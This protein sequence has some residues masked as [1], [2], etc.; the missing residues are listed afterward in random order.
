MYDKANSWLLSNLYFIPTSKGSVWRLT[1]NWVILSRLPRYGLSKLQELLVDIITGSS[2]R[3][4][5]ESKEL[6]TNCQL[7]QCQHQS[8]S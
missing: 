7:C 4:S 2:S 6:L 1:I 8:Q 3:C 5:I